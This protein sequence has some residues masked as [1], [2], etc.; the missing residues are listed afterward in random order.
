MAGMNDTLPLTDG[1]AAPSVPQMLRHQH[2]TL[3]A[4]V[5]ALGLVLLV[6]GWSAYARQRA[7][8]WWTLSS[9]GEQLQLAL[10]DTLDVARSHVSAMRLATE[11]NLRQP[12]LADNG[13]IDR[14]DR[15][16]QAP[17]RDAPWDRL[18]ED[19]VKDIGAV[20]IDPSP[21]KDGLSAYRRDI[22][23]PLGALAQVAA[24]HSQHKRL[25]WSYFLD[26][27][28]QWRWVYPAQSREQI[29]SAT[30][31]A[32]M[33]GGLAMLWDA[34]GTTPLDAAG[35]TRNPN[36]ELVWTSA[37]TD[38][39]MKTG[40]VSVLAPVYAAERYVGVVGTDLT[41]DAL[42]TVLQERALTLGNAWVI[43]SQGQVL[44]HSPTA[45]ATLPA[46]PRTADEGWLQFALR[47]TNWSLQVQAPRG[48][49]AR[50]T[51]AA[52]VPMLITSVLGLLAAVGV[53]LW[54]GKRYSEPA[55]ALADYVRSTD[56]PHIKRPPPM[57]PLWAPWFESALRFALQRRDHAMAQ[58]QHIQQL[59]LQLR[60]QALA[61][62]T[63]QL[64]HEQAL[65]GKAAELRSAYAQLSATLA[66]HGQAPAPTQGESP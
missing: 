29:L 39:I 44:A 63:T 49:L 15:R 42:S 28:K 40:V 18:P 52:L 24:A 58:H 17:L 31:Q 36:K 5:G 19:I 25:Q 65:A 23:A 35:P 33:T 51:W 16:N 14:L 4:I 9:Q 59:E 46:G 43:D 3:A 7:T 26:A 47:G 55:L 13:V 32:D 30:G 27:Q 10:N 41:L 34:A 60:E 8:L 50:A 45:A 20:Q 54:L 12:T 1:P 66:Q 6:I 38:P 56:T 2:R 61:L 37:H 22:Q 64:E 48:K 11:R 53:A 21:G 62:R 57:P